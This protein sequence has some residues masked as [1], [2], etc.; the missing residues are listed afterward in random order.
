MRE[1]KTKFLFLHFLVVPQKVLWRPLTPNEKI[2]ILA[3]F[4]SSSGIEME[5]VN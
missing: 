5:R 2:K 4:L 3:N 1:N